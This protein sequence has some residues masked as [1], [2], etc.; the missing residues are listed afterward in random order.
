MRTRLLL[1][2]L[3]TL[4]LM[5][6]VACGDDDDDADTA[7]T[8]TSTTTT[9]VGGET[10]SLRTVLKGGAEEVPDPGDPDGAGD[11]VVTFRAGQVCYQISTQ[12]IGDATLAHIHE[13]GKGVA[14]P[15]VVT[16]DPPVGGASMGCI[17]ADP[18]LI[19]RIEADPAGFYVNV[20]T[21]EFP[22]GA[23]R[24]QLSES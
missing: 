22:K 3:S 14:G 7:A 5:T 10:T 15:I 11:A 1:L 13:G 16:F 4:V 24:G 19:T 12:N 6:G 2:M 20:H 17:D 23:I 8:A 9:V 21:A 18:A